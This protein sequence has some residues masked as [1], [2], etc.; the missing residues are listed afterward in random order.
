MNSNLHP[1]NPTALSWQG[2]PARFCPQLPYVA[3]NKWK[4]QTS[5]KS[6]P[7]EADHSCISKKAHSHVAF[8]RCDLKC[9]SSWVGGA[10]N[11]RGVQL[12]EET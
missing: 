5:R 3:R 7:N 9:A 4:W 11:P 10:N 1:E 12:N 2:N 6:P 8:C